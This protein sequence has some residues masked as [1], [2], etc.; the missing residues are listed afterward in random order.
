MNIKFYIK[1]FLKLVKELLVINIQL[2]VVDFFGLG[3]VI[4]FN[5]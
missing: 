1:V 4:L 5:F 2:Y 3:K